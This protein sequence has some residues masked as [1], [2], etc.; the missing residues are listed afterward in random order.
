MTVVKICGT[1]SLE[2]ALLAAE[3]GADLLGFILYPNSPR[4]VPPEQVARI[5]EALHR[6]VTHPPR[7][8]G[9]FVN[10]S[11]AEIQNFLTDSFFDYAQL[12]GD[13]DETWLNT[14]GEPA[15]KAIRPANPAQALA[16]SAQLALA[17]S[18]P[19]PHLLLDAY[20]PHAYGGTGQRADWQTAAA[21][22]RNVDHLLLAGGLTPDNVAAALRTVRP[23][24]VDVASGVEERPGVKNPQRLRAFLEAVRS[25]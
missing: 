12:H 6:C 13:E 1:T 19:G 25:C 11:V 23:W 5:V 8:V 15:F 3:A 21:V 16:Q 2:D 18:A 7:C 4:Y 10:A 22:A 17:Q 20:T 24:G 9:V 14:L